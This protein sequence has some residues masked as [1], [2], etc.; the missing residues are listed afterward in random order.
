MPALPSLRQLGY[1]VELAERLNFRAAA[2]AQFVT[3]STLSAGIKELESVLGVQLVERDKRHVR[4]TAVGEDVVARARELLAGA[5]D[6]AEIA[7]SAMAPLNG[8]LRLGVIPTIAPYLLPQVLPPL[9]RA[10]PELTLYLRE[11][12]TS[13]LLERLRAG[14]LDIAL[15][16]LPYDTGDL[17]VI[18]LFKDE[19][20]F[21]AREEDP[22]AGEKEITL[23]KIDTGEVILLEEGHC[24][25]DHAISACGPRRG[26]W[27]SRIEATSLPTLIQMVDGGLGVTLLPELTLKA[28]VLKGTRL[29][30]RPFASPAPSRMLALVT[31]RTSPRRRD[32]ELLAEFILEQ[33]R[34]SARPGIP[35]LRRARGA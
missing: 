11:D 13:H 23:R 15:I 8:P 3:Q 19:F 25:R 1:L 16:A 14:S 21:V 7:K 24:L 2:E 20:W 35:A 34:R 31:R 4:M 33:R 6:L 29:I 12:L 10:H 27:E 18:P 22:A 17:H 28:G 9:R 26:T 30:A 5:N 32:A